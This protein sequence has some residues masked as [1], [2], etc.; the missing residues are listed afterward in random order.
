MPGL[1]LSA[2]RRD[3]GRDLSAVEVAV[4]PLVHLP[5]PRFVTP[6]Q[7]ESFKYWEVVSTVMRLTGASQEDTEAFI[8]RQK[9]VIPADH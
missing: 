4:R 9:A 6:F 1:R 8:K 3:L 2:L 5:D 7:V